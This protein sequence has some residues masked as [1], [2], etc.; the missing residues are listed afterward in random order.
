MAMRR[1]RQLPRMMH[2]MH[3][4]RILVIFVIRKQLLD[5]FFLE[6]FDAVLQ[7]VLVYVF[8]FAFAVFFVVILILWRLKR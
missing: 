6:E 5:A 8:P 7:A 2:P 1:L 3:W 4:L